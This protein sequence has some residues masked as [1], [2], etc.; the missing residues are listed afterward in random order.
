MC[1]LLDPLK[2]SV[3]LNPEFF[4]KSLLTWF[5]QA[6]RDMPWRENKDPY[7]IW[8]SEIMLQQTQVATVRPYF[9]RFMQAFPT[10][11]ALAEAPLDRVLKNWE[12]LGYYSRARNLQKG[13]QY[14]L[15][16]HQ[17]ELPQTLS[18][19]LAVPGI[20]PYS[21]G[22][23]LSI[24]FDQ[25]VP[26][27]DGNVIRV[28]SRLLRLKTPF[29]KAQPKRELEQVVQGLIPADAAGDFNQALM[30]LGALI[31]RPRQ[32]RCLE[33]PM[34]DLCQAAANGNPEAYPVKGK[35]TKVK[36]VPMAVLFL[37]S[38]QGVLLQQQ[39]A[40]GI[41]RDLW[42]LPWSEMPLDAAAAFEALPFSVEISPQ[43]TEIE[44]VLTHRRL[45]MRVFLGQA[46][47]KSLPE[48]FVWAPLD[49][50]HGYAIPVA[51]QKIFRFLVAHPLLLDLYGADLSIES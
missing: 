38:P 18:E 4:Q 46:K 24:A 49:Q 1:D 39:G 30:E 15:A 50:A 6:A 43:L 45:Q 10:V 8:V 21:A 41:F 5:K 27:V 16:Q 37:Q 3:E 23:I 13:A 42:C 34:Q 7:R 9:E 22:A 25:A 2:P 32:P 40:K 31:C 17:G 19:I 26:A 20:G 12:G 29:D 36:T 14:L 11:R 33:C 47:L 51:H 44:H 48:G 28:F 35:K